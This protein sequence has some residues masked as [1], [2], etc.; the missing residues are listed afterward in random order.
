MSGDT[1]APPGV[2]LSASIS[3][4]VMEIIFRPRDF[5]FPLSSLEGTTE[6]Q[7]VQLSLPKIGGAPVK[8]ELAAARE[9]PRVV[10][11]TRGENR[12]WRWDDS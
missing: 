2:P 9:G 7:S 4:T 5:D 1:H 12:D 8:L 10:T 6:R 11:F 3:G